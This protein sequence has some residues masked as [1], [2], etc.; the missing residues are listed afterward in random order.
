METST[1]FWATLDSWRARRAAV[2]GKWFMIYFWTQIFMIILAFL[3]SL[4]L[5]NGMPAVL[6][7]LL[8]YGYSVTEVVIFYQLGRQ[9]DRFKTSAG[10]A[11]IAL[12]A[13]IIIDLLHSNV[14][15]VLWRIPGGIIKLIAVYHFMIGCSEILLTTDG[16][17]SD[18]WR[19]LWKWYID[20]RVGLIVGLPALL[21]MALIFESTLL[22]NLALILV[23]GIAIA[24]V[25]VAI[26]WLVYLYRTARCFQ[27]IGK[28]LESSPGS[29]AN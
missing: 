6:L 10:L 26:L 2:F 12:V 19:S 24:L 15:A 16:K 28:T 14:L 21:I 27:Q 13:G 9:E 7:V 29:D 1:S 23:I 8:S 25:V 18:K 11:L 5:V 22:A 4:W 20:L 3:S 17:L